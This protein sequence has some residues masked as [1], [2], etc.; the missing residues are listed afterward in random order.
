MKNAFMWI[1][2]C[3]KALKDLKRYLSGPP[4]LSKLMEGEQLL[5]YLA[6]SEVAIS[7]ILI[8]EE[9]A[10]AY[11]KIEEREVINFIWDNNICWFGVPKE[12][13]CDNGRQFIGFKVI[14]ILERLKISQI[15]SSPYHASVNGQVE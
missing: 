14:K 7:A 5:I 11:I 10:S 2:E 13:T 3:Q 12:I 9:E 8:R 15:T 4:L 6:V 1:P